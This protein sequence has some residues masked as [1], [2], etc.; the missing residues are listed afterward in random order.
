[1]SLPNVQAEQVR[2]VIERARGTALT[3]G[4][5]GL[6]LWGVGLFNQ[7]ELAFQGYHFAYIFWAGLSIGCLGMTLLVHVVRG[8]WGQPLVRIFEAGAQTLVPMMVILFIPIL[9]GM[10][11]IFEWSHAEAVQNDPII[12]FKAKYYLNLP[13]FLVRFVLYFV[14]WGGMTYLMVRSSTQQ[15]AANDPVEAELISRQRMTPAAVSIPLYVLAVTF[16]TVDMAMSLQPHWFSTMY[17]V[18]FLVGFGLTAMALATLLVLLWRDLPPYK[19]L[20]H[21][22]FR[23][24]WGNLLFTMTVFWSYVSFSQLLII[25]SGNLPEETSFYLRRN[26]GGWHPVSWLIV[27]FHFFVPFFLLLAPRTKRIP[28]QLILGAVILLAIRVVEIFWEIKPAFSATFSVS[29]WDVAA[30]VGLGGL[31]FW[32]MFGYLLKRPLLPQNEPRLL[33]VAHEH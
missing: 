17:G 14:L 11:A 8:K 2:S 31:W 29:L 24:D 5:I 15:D 33:E 18:I 26:S 22:E 9:L 6:I 20:I 1:M 32:A 3:L 4:I 19:G 7:R 21:F 23:R 10:H 25:Y 27:L 30:F 12:A 13:F 28:Q 16:F